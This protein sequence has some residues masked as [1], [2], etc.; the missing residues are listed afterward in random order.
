MPDETGTETTRSDAP[1]ADESL[2][3]DAANDAAQAVA[4]EQD[5]NEETAHDRQDAD[6]VE[7][8][9]GR[10]G[11]LKVVVS[12]KGGRATIGVQQPSSDPHIETFDD[13]DLSGL[14]QEVSAV[15]ERARAKMGGRTQASGSRETRSPRQASDPA[16]ARVGAGRGR[17]GRGGPAATRDAAAVLRAGT[18]SLSPPSSRCSSGSSTWSKSGSRSARD[19]RPQHAGGCRRYVSD[20]LPLRN[21][22]CGFFCVS[23][24]V[25]A[26]RH[27][28][29][30]SQSVNRWPRPSE[31][32]RFS[33]AIMCRVLGRTP[34]SLQ[35]LI[36]CG[37]VPRR[38][39][40]SAHGRADSSWNR[41][42]RCGK[43][44][45]KS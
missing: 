13:Q 1:S 40:N 15:I 22:I 39:F 44:S 18:A 2:F 7:E 3:G 16:F 20:G 8:E 29:A 30:A 21:P 9:A 31:S 14:T 24:P 26:A 32:A 43:S 35:R 19:A 27:R 45:G 23:G 38:R 33:S 6:D 28:S 41:T 11:D 42:S 5:A 25:A 12:I 37:S 36:V 34:S 10:P 4:D 17:R